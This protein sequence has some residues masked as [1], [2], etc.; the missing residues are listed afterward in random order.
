MHF[1]M[2]IRS[3]FIKLSNA[4]QDIRA[5]K[6][7]MLYRYFKFLHLE[8]KLNQQN[9][10][11]CSNNDYLLSFDLLGWGI[12]FFPNLVDFSVSPL[13]R[14][15]SANFVHAFELILRSQKKRVHQSSLIKDLNIC[16]NNYF[17][18]FHI[19]YSCNLFV[20]WESSH[21]ILQSYASTMSNQ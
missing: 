9:P 15:I 1:N 4:G 3:S 21:G 20:L 16:Y 10:Q 19:T 5:L 2:E 13:P 6:E 14:E 7:D 18:L 17:Y 11:S 8:K 12:S